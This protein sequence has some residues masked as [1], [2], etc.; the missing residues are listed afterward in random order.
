MIKLK[1]VCK[2]QPR[3]PEK[4]NLYYAQAVAKGRVDLDRLA[5]LIA[6]QTT[7]S[8]ADCFAVVVAMVDTISDQLLQGNI[9]QVD[10]LGAFKLTVQSS[11]SITATEVSKKSIVKTKL[12]FRPDS[13]FKEKLNTASFKHE[14]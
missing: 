14:S 5:D 12:N 7:L 8:R 3:H 13:R 6:G 2:S 10:R 9:V 4:Q 1:T 11:P